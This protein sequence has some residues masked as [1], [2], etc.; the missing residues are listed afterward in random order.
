MMYVTNISFKQVDI[1]SC[2]QY[3]LLNKDELENNKN[4]NN[5][6]DLMYMLHRFGYVSLKCLLKC[7]VQ[8][9]ETGKMFSYTISTRSGK[10]HF[11]L[12]IVF[13][14][15]TDFHLKNSFI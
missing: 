14:C 3:L 13:F 8:L 1:I 9:E 5:L 6:E 10:L 7:V 2:R 4:R 11:I 15:M 12:V